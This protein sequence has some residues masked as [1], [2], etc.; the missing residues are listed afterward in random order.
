M[1]RFRPL[2]AL[3]LAWLLLL[4]PPFAAAKSAMSPALP[5]HACCAGMTPASFHAHTPLP[6][7]AAGAP[8]A[9]HCGCGCGIVALLPGSSGL[10][11]YLRHDRLAIPPRRL[12]LHATSE[13]PLRPPRRNA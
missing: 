4:A 2:L 8:C 12:H 10:N 7:H 5:G 3:L 1:R 9:H 6:V 13:P 11:F